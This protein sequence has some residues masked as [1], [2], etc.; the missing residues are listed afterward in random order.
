MRKFTLEINLD[1]DAMQDSLD[2]AAAI[3]EV[4][5]HM[6]DTLDERTYTITDM[7]MKHVGT[8]RFN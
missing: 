3:R 4:A 8:A 6:A 2:I 5:D 1:G 7:N